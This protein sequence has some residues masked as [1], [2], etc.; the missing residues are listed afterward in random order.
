MSNYLSK[1]FRAGMLSNFFGT[2]SRPTAFFIRLFSDGVVFD[3]AIGAG[4]DL[5]SEANLI[6]ET[7]DHFRNKCRFIYN[8]GSSGTEAKPYFTPITT[9]LPTN[10]DTDWPG[11][12]IMEQ[13]GSGYEPKK[14]D[15]SAFKISVV[16]ASGVNGI[17]VM[18]DD[19]EWTTTADDWSGLRW[20]VVTA[21]FPT[22]LTPAAGGG[23]EPASSEEYIERVLFAKD[24]GSGKTVT[25]VGAKITVDDLY[26]QI[27][28]N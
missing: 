28:G 17:K 27:N 26:F 13:L 16:T 18:L 3:G 5:V 4:S 14:L 15:T 10:R 20:A 6:S 8:P 2:T 23:F 19:Q 1:D 12:N 9:G 21:V 22:G 25:G 11:Y 24:Y 7:S